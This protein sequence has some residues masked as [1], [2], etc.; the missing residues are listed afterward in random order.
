MIFYLGNVSKMQIDVK[1]FISTL[2]WII[3]LDLFCLMKV[4]CVCFNY[5]LDL[6]QNSEVHTNADFSN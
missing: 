2:A 1:L 4:V 5:S 6:R 3:L